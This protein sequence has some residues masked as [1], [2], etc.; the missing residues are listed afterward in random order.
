MVLAILGLLAAGGVGVG[1]KI[2]ED[3]GL[4][5]F[6][7]ESEAMLA[8][9]LA[10]RDAAIMNTQINTCRIGSGDM[11][12]TT[13]DS[14]GRKNSRKIVFETFTVD[15]A[16]TMTFEFYSTG[17]ISG[18]TDRTW[19]FVLRGPNGFQRKMVFQPIVG[20]I[21]LTDAKQN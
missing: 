14:K 4:K 1:M 5:A 12:L 18:A 19:N 11:M 21:Y 16:G 3:N 7:A 13:F 2:L 8:E 17:V 9:I 20:R 15:V 6:N 10:V